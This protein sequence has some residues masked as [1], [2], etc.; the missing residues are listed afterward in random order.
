MLLVPLDIYSL[1]IAIIGVVDVI[2]TVIVYI[3]IYLPVR[4]HKNQIQV[5]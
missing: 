3:R 5:L 4:R 2:I 1:I